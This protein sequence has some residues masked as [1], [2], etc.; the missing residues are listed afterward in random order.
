[1]TRPKNKWWIEMDEDDK[2][3][4]NIGYLD[5]IIYATSFLR[6]GNFE[7]CD[8]KLNKV[9]KINFEKENNYEN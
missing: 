7:M 5:N 1:M 6:K 2:P 4:L 8:S 9:R 3:E